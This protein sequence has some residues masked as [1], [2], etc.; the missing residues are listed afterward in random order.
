MQST[1]ASHPSC[2]NPDYPS[3]PST[4]R[5]KTVRYGFFRL[6]NGSRRR[7]YRCTACGKTF[8]STKNTPYYRLHGTRRDFDQVAAMSVEGVSRSA[9]AR[10]KSLS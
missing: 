2:P 4:D 5:A 7:R 10:I 9:I 3:H 1:R 8:S 6:K